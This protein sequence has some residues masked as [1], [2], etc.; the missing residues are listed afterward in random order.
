MKI[1]FYSNHHRYLCGTLQVVRGTVRVED[2]DIAAIT[3]TLDDIA[4]AGIEIGRDFDLLFPE[5]LQLH[6]AFEGVYRRGEGVTVAAEK[7]D[8]AGENLV[9]YKV[10][11]SAEQTVFV[12]LSAH[13]VDS[14]AY[15]VGALCCAGWYH[16]DSPHDHGHF[17]I[18]R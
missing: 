14:C 12:S 7:L 16:S 13:N 9:V 2:L 10:E 17:T 5:T 15:A 11:L 18:I 8:L 4:S 6:I 1:S 3:E